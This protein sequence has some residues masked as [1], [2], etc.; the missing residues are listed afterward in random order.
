MATAKIVFA[1]MTGNNEEIAEIVQEGLEDAGVDVD[2]TEISQADASEFEDVDICIIAT[3][4]YGEAN[5]PDEAQD[6]FEDLQTVDL[7]GKVYGCC[8][9]GDTFYDNF[10][11]AVDDFSKVFADNGAIQGAPNVKIDLAPETEDIEKLDQFTAQIV[12]KQKELG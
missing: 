5:L 10:C 11:S 1:S 12:A 3:Y 6:F 2:V 7:T 4:T 8:G 9:S